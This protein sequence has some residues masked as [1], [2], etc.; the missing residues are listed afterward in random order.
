MYGSIIECDTDICYLAVN[1]EFKADNIKN[2]KD[3]IF[4][5]EHELDQYISL[6]I[7]LG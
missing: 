1:L 6:D 5:K 3:H 4:Y 7:S 2:V